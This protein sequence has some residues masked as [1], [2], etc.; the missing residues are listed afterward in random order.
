MQYRDTINTI[1]PNAWLFVINNAAYKWI[2]NRGLQMHVC[3]LI[4]SPV[5][6]TFRKERVKQDLS[7]TKLMWHLKIIIIKKE[8]LSESS[9]RMAQFKSCMANDS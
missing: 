9:L 4:R 5:K 6:D 7:S 8:R 1:N 2:S 3:S